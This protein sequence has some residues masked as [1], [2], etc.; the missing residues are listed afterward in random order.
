MFTELK[1]FAGIH[2]NEDQ[3]NLWLT[4][5]LADIPA[6]KRILDAGAGELRN[7]PLCLHLDYVSQDICQ[8]EGAQYS[9][10]PQTLF[11]C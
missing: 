3:R 8:Y 2:A 1:K 7:K 11:L 4:K 10:V 5:I 6:G 9:G